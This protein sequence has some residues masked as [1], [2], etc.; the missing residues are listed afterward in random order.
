MHNSHPINNALTHFAITVAETIVL[1]ATSKLVND[2]RQL[3]MGD[4]FCAVIGSQINGRK[5]IPQALA[6]N[7]ALIIAECE[8]E[9]GHG[10]IETVT[11]ANGSSILIINI[12]Q[13]NQH[14]FDLASQFYNYPQRKLQLIGITG[15]NG[16]TSISQ[17]TAKLLSTLNKPCA[18]I[19]TNGAGLVDALT[20]IE[21]TT[22]GSTELVTWLKSF[23]QE[24]I[25][26]VA[27]E[28]SSHALAQKRVSGEL[29][30]IAVFSN[31]S[32]DHLD[33]HGTMES[34]AETKYQI[35]TQQA[36]QIAIIN[37]D[38]N[39]A[40]KW[41]SNWPA[42]QPVIVYGR[43][44]LITQYVAYAKA[45]DISHSQK[46]ACFT[47]ST[48]LGEIEI[49]SPLLGDFNIDNLLAAIA[50]LMANNVRLTE[51]ASAV[52]LLTPITGRMEAYFNKNA[53]TTVVDYAHTP[54]GLKNALQACRQHCK[55]QLWV[56]F[57]CGGDRD[58][59][60]RPLMGQVA[61]QMADK[62]VL[63]NDNPRTEQ[64]QNIINDIL[65]GCK[66]TAEIT[67]EL[68]R[69]LAVEQTIKSA[70]AG[71]V[72]LLAGK[73]HENYVVIGTEKV[74]YDERALVKQL[75]LSETLI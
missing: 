41:L 75:Y 42:S 29:F 57:G 20:E 48:H 36:D 38:D 10:E 58:K 73:G 47:L 45:S 27:M 65:A 66:N 52:S 4:V 30:D 6:Q 12:F 11:T 44:D 19:G 53:P 46:G 1:N 61:Q 34:Y 26:H 49:Q 39:Q 43:S 7:V 8:S 74:P 59:G 69:Q 63:T 9:Q 5:F 70:K 33:Y 55:G 40:S 18:V 17:L 14:L 56:V 31:L 54:D 64:P 23:E 21:N 50:V 25:T 2:S 68:N 13:L 67:I 51:V 71:D 3:V 15:T 72:V 22:P 60:K 62:I 28:V 16:K 37:G 35:F 32:R 24:K